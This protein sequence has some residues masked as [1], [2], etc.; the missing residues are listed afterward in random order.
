LKVNLMPLTDLTTSQAATL[1]QVHESSLK[2]W[3]NSGDFALERT[4]GGHRR[5]P[6]TGLLDFAHRKGLDALLLRLH[7]FEAEV[8]SAALEA[9]ERNDYSG[10]SKL[11]LQFCDS[12][13]PLALKGLMEFLTQAAELPMTRVMDQGFGAALREVGRQWE[14]GSRSV[15][16]EH[17]FTQKVLDALHTLLH[18]TLLEK[19]PA[20]LASPSQESR[21]AIVACA[22]GCYHEIGSMMVRILLER[23]GWDALYLGANV[24]F[25]EIAMAQESQGSALVCLSFVPPLSAADVR[26]CLK[27]LSALHNPQFPYAL[28]LGGASLSPSHTEGVATP[29]RSVKVCT[30]MESLSRWLTGWK[31][32]ET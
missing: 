2:R 31:P 22:E 14:D 20:P 16:L 9:R 5:I 30:S 7:P 29:F 18:Q 4:T 24:P 15:A 1:L 23:E 6:L 13:S 10:I 26:R 12:E 11:I 8:A 32:K 21:K 19:Y 25:E 27:V 28:A 17:R 3:A